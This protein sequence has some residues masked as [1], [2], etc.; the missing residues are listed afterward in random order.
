[1]PAF[2]NLFAL[3]ST[4][5]ISVIIMAEKI[6]LP[7]EYLGPGEVYEEGAKSYSRGDDIFSAVM[8]QVDEAGA[9]VRAREERPALSRG[10]IVY[11]TI[12]MAMESFAIAAIFPE[13]KGNVL[14]AAVDEGKIPVRAMSTGFT[15]SVRDAVRIGDLIRAK[16]VKVEGEKAELTLAEPEL[17]VIKAFCSQCRKPLDKTPKGLECSNGHRERRETAKDYR[18]YGKLDF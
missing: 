1:M 9:E 18:E 11:G 16:V 15:P 3:K 7:G 8:G 4:S 5:N 2:L 12:V 6:V 13:K 14:P 17:G 10:D